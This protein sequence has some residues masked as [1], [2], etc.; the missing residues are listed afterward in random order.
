MHASEREQGTS[1]PDHHPD[2]LTIALLGGPTVH[3][4][5]LECPLV[6][7]KSAALLYYLAAHPGQPHG[8]SH[9][10]ALLWEESDDAAARNSLSTALSRLR[11]VAPFPIHS[12]GDRLTWQPDDAVVSDLEQF[13]RLTTVSGEDNPRVLETAVALYRG[14][15]LAGFE[16]RDSEGAE[17]WLRQEREEWQDRVLAVYRRLVAA[18][19][20]RGQRIAAID[21]GQRALAIDP[22]QEAMHRTLMRLHHEEGN[23]AS[24]LAQFRA[25]E[26]AL[27]ETFDADPAPETRALRD[28]IARGDTPAAGAAPV[29][30][31]AGPEATQR[32]RYPLIGRDRELRRLRDA[33]AGDIARQPRMIVIEGEAG[34]GKT[35]LVEELPAW[36]A[37]SGERWTLLLGHSYQDAQGL[38]YHP[39]VEALRS[40]PTLLDVDRLRLPDTWL[41]EVARLL[42]EINAPRHNLPEPSPLDPQQERRRLF[43]GVAHLLAALPPPRLLI[44][45]DVHWADSETL[46]L[47]AYLVRHDALRDTRFFVTLR[48]DDTSEMVR[49]ILD[50]LEYEGWLERLAIPPL[51][52]AMTAELV[53]AII[54][55]PVAELA[56]QTYQEAEGNPLFTVELVRSLV[57]KGIWQ[58]DQ[59]PPRMEHVELPAT[60]QAAIRSRLAQL[61]QPSR[62]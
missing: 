1:Q 6:Y 28:T 4:G 61:D 35:R 42:P 2:S 57:E 26:R 15:F 22:A 46:H 54:P 34:I 5:A 33:L 3:V 19:Q 40:Q 55:D 53:Q 51:T 58:A 21:A 47:L 50:S 8:R 27:R 43:E 30:P 62:D 31:R 23:R 9:L 44:L 12:A 39:F 52:V 29:P 10:A 16:L 41:V 18:Y 11:R 14:Q 17:S 32:F 59:Q 24:A 7:R 45:E 48:S 36:L 49:R 38:P 25:C 56:E 60:V 20:L 37:E 13:R